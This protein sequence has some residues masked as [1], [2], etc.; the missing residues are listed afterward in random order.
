MFSL[1]GSVD[2][3]GNGDI[4]LINSYFVISGLLQLHH[5]YTS[6]CFKT[7]C[8]KK[9]DARFWCWLL[10]F[11]KVLRLSR[12]KLGELSEFRPL[13]LSSPPTTAHKQFQALGEFRVLV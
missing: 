12:L 4:T 3:S 1:M 7:V 6:V 10:D 13:D 11:T 9:V 2:S 8:S 5:S